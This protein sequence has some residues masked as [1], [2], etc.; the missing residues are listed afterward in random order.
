MGKVEYFEAVVGREV[1]RRVRGAR[2]RVLRELAEAEARELA[3]T[4]ARVRERVE[5]ATREMERNANRAVAEATREAKT[6]YN[7]IRTAFFKEVRR[8]VIAELRA[9]TQTMEYVD[10]LKEKIAE[11]MRDGLDKLLLRPQDMH[12][13][14][15]I[16]KSTDDKISSIE[17]GEDDFIGGFIL[18]GEKVRSDHTFKT[19]LGSL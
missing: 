19:R 16:K 15:E 8:E 7:T 2:V 10:Y 4:R 9:F 13:A 11:N 3:E 14:E 5:E 12:F 6:E 17:I 18:L 1:E